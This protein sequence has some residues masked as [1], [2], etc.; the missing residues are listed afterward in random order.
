MRILLVSISIAGLAG[1]GSPPRPH[2][3]FVVPTVPAGGPGT[4]DPVTE[5]EATCPRV[6]VTGQVVRPGRVRYQPGLTVVGA[7]VA[8]GGKTRD[9]NGRQV[10]VTRVVGGASHRYRV[11]LGPILGG[12]ADDFALRAGDIVDVPVDTF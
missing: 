7:I 5:S 11:P 2:S 8:C 1:C 4:C 3:Q 12:D 6:A 10:H 9:A